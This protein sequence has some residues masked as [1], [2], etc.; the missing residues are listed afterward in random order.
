M[1]LA[2]YITVGEWKILHLGDLFPDTNTDIFKKLKINNKGVDILMADYMFILSEKS[3]YILKNLIQ[4]EAIIA[5]HISPDEIA[6]R[7]SDL[8]EAFPGIIVFSKQGETK[9]FK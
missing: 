7:K 9:L 3:Q 2:F 4:P 5:M 6:N 8:Q 1:T